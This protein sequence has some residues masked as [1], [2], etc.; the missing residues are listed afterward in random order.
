MFST[1]IAT[2]LRKPVRD[3]ISLQGE[4]A[5]QSSK[6]DYIKSAALCQPRVD[7]MQVGIDV[8]RQPVKP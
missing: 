6:Y 1:A 5:I 3:A 7:Q 2:G 4:M 8:A